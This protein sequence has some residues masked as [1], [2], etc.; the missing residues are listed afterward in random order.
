M[1]L[2]EARDGAILIR[3]MDGNGW[4]ITGINES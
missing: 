3:E 1:F 2:D 4:S